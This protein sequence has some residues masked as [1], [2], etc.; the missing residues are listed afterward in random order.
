VDEK[1]RSALAHASVKVVR[2]AEAV[3]KLKRAKDRRG[4]TILTADEVDGLVWGLQTLRGP[5]DADAAAAP[6]RRRPAAD[7]G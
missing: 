5:D 7:G 2:F 1:E 3:G 4:G 6:G